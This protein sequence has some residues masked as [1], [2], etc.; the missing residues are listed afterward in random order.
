MSFVTS[1]I[2]LVLLLFT[3][4]QAADSSVKL[5]PIRRVD[6][7]SG[8]QRLVNRHILDAPKSK[9]QNVGTAFV[10]V[11][12]TSW[13]AGLVP[14]FVIETE[15]TFELRRLPARGQ[16]NHSEP[17][18]FAL[19]PEDETNAVKICG[20]WNGVASNSQRSNHSPNWELA[21]D[22]ER[23]AGR[24]DPGGEYRVAFISGGTFRSN[25][26]ELNVEY[27]NDRYALSGEWRDG[28][29]A[30][31][32]QQVDDSDRGTWQ[33]TRQ[34]GPAVL[35][36]TA[37]TLP[38]YEWRRGEARRYATEQQMKEVG[39]QR[40]VRPLCRVWRSDE[41]TKNQKPSSR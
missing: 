31:T 34:A 32:W 18:F 13:P 17:L 22:G 16:E 27:I 23:V 5:E 12:S 29:L 19:P 35:P 14:L 20:K 8:T 9:G 4:G 30:G 39:W 36:G 41:N 25:R 7:V 28:K 21:I 40:A 6:L 33:A 1:S 3:R 2:I 24:F 15:N 11:V 37:N 38:L 10:A 26:F